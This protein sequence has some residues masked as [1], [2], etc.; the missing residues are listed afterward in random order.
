MNQSQNQNNL[1]NYPGLDM[2]DREKVEIFVSCRSLAD[3]DAFSKSDPFVIM[4]IQNPQTKQ[5]GELFRTEVI[6]D[7]L[8]PN[9]T[10]SCLVDYIFEVQ[11]NVRFQV[12]DYDGPN[13]SDFIG[14]VNSTIAQIVGSKNQTLILDLKDNNGRYGGKIILRAEKVNLV[15]DEIYLRIKGK[16]IKDLRFWGKSCPFLIFYRSSE[17]K[18]PIKVFQ[19]EVVERN[20]DPQFA[21]INIKAQKLCN[22]DYQMP[23]IVECWDHHSNGQHEY[24]GQTQFSVAELTSQQNKEFKL[25]NKKKNSNAGSL[26]VQ[27]VKLIEKPQFLDY[28]RGGTHLNLVCAVDFT[29]SNGVPTRPESLHAINQYGQ[30]NQYQQAIQF[31]GEILLNYDED[32]MV[33]LYGFGAKPKL[34][35]FNYTQTLH[36]FP[37][38]GNPMNP[39]VYGLKGMMDTYANFLNFVELSGPTLFNPL[40][41]ETMKLAQISKQQNDNNYYILLILTDGEI[42]DMEQTTSSIVQSALLPLSIIIV[43][44]GNADFNNMDILDG[45]NGLID[46][47]GRKA[48]RDLV[49]FVPF[50]RYKNNPQALAQNVLEELPDQVVEYYRLVG[51][52]PVQ[53]VYQRMQS[54]Q[55][56]NVPQANQQFGQNLI[57]AGFMNNIINNTMNDS[58]RQNAQNYPPP[59]DNQNLQNYPPPP[60]QNFQN[61]PGQNM[62]F[63]YNQ[64]QA[65][66]NQQ[67]FGMNNSV[68][69]NQPQKNYVNYPSNP[70]NIP[71][72]SQYVAPPPP[73]PM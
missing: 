46:S 26:V 64:G 62:N 5:W 71:N 13:S 61:Y 10:K 22:G 53:P 38:N 51:Q 20:L 4:Q 63:S 47:N 31:V 67:F 25:I 42:H 45:D 12:F 21:I 70:Q 7:N 24:I 40:I 8:N 32:K 30:L 59:P 65:P 15:N 2:S 39:Q 19:T 28:I 14:E 54:I 49:Q 16:G 66:P 11:Q 44:I 6:M 73:P 48:Q 55:V 41:Q 35:H 34:P 57:K 18:Q 3:K 37:I 58:Q 23:I 52:K 33:P 27:E 50:N 1:Q 36:C 69:Q 9:F 43:G 17:N 72:Y 56:Q 68:N 60:Q 29:G